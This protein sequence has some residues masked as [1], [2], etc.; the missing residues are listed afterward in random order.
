MCLFEGKNIIAV[1]SRVLCPR[2]LWEQIPRIREAG[3][4]RVILREKDLSSGEYLSLAEKVL[5]ACEECGVSLTIH[6]FPEAAESLGVKSLHMP[7]PLMEKDLCRCFSSLGT[8]VHSIEQ[9]RASLMSL[10]DIF[11]RRTVKKTSLREVFGF[12][13]ISVKIRIFR[14][15]PSAE[16]LRKIFR[17]SFFA[18]RREHVSCPPRCGCKYG[19]AGTGDLYRSHR[20]PPQGN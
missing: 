6:S 14:C 8:S 2:P 4:T 19:H 20:K 3:I 9:L 15:M 18:E 12:C 1:T 16:S 7:L 10:P 5:R 11:L 13:Q 17:K